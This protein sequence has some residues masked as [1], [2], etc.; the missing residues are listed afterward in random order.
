M[1]IYYEKLDIGTKLEA[2]MKRI[3]SNQKAK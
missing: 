1:N 2:K 3:N